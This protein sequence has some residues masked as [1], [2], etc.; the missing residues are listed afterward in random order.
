MI[1]L[2][3]TAFVAGIALIVWGAEAFAEHLGGAAAGLSVSSF[4]LALLLAG[5]E[6]EELATVVTASLKGAP[7]IA[8]GDVIGA[9]VAIC[10]VALS[11]GA[12]VALLPFTG[13]VRRYALAGLPL[14]AI[15]AWTA[16]DGTVI[17]TIGKPDARG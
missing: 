10:L 1:V 8:V 14:G 15:A 2:W 4:A 13:S 9:N 7:G 5:A 3:I 17:P 16:W 6:P 11:V 12:L